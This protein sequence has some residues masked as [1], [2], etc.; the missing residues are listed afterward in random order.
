MSA[1]VLDSAVT[2]AWFMPKEITAP[3]QELLD[4]VGDDGALVPSLW[5]LEVGNTL[6]LAA[7]RNLISAENCATAIATLEE[8]PIELD[9]ETQTE[10]WNATF[11]LAAQFRL[12]LYDACNLEL[13]RRRRLPLASLDKELRSAASQLGLDLLGV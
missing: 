5:F 11:R 1:L 6:L 7:R 3:T 2:M 12:T 9:T 13:A 8:L 4:I 10:A